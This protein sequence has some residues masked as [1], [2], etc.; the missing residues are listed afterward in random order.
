[1]PIKTA[2][3]TIIADNNTIISKF[4]EHLPLKLQRQLKRKRISS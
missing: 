3:V 2:R 1:M 4:T